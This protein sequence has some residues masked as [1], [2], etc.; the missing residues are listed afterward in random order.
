MGSHLKR[1]L[2]GCIH[3]MRTALEEPDDVGEN[4]VGRKRG[5]GRGVVGDGRRTKEDAGLGYTA[6]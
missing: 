6:G 5:R 2:S 4:C 3:K 1:V